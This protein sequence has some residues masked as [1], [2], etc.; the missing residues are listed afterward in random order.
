MY[1]A[2]SEN[3]DGSVSVHRRNRTRASRRTEVADLPSAFNLL[4]LVRRAHDRADEHR[5]DLHESDGERLSQT[6]V[7]VDEGDCEG[8]V[9]GRSTKGRKVD[10][11]SRLLRVNTSMSSF[12]QTGLTVCEPKSASQPLPGG[13]S[14]RTHKVCPVDRLRCADPALDGAVVAVVVG[15]REAEDGEG[16]VF[17]LRGEGGVVD[18]GGEGK[19]AA[20]RSE[21]RKRQ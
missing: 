12:T 8:E 4:T 13:S 9:S 3:D 17:E 19:V 10:A 21:E 1:R 11:P 5:A 18:E 16:A 7:G 6:R 15:W 20:L 14:G 2:V